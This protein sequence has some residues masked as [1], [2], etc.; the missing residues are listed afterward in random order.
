MINFLQILNIDSDFSLYLSHLFTKTYNMKQFHSVCLALA[1]VLVSLASNSAVVLPAAK[2]ASNNAAEM[3]L[4]LGKSG[5]KISLLDFSTIKASEL[6]TLSGK[7]MNFVQKM[8]FKSFQKKLRK[9]INADGTIDSKKLAKLAT[10]GKASEES[11]KYLR[12]WLI[13]LGAAILFSILGIFVPFLWIISL[14]A[15]LGAT[16]FFVLWLIAL[17]G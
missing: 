9:N 1:F 4:P 12:L 5:N 14:L 15:G 17:A 13:L 2:P 3:Y 11:S 6:E 10:K 16:I 8:G 7:K